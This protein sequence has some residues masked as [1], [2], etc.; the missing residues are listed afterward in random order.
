MATIDEVLQ[1]IRYLHGAELRG[2]APTPDAGT[3]HVFR[4]R[5]ERRGSGSDAS[6]PCF[7]KVARAPTVAGATHAFENE[8]AVLTALSTS[9]IP[10]PA[11]HAAGGAPLPYLLLGALPGVMVWD[12]VDPRRAAHVPAAALH[13]LAQ[14]G[15]ALARIH[16]LPLA[17]SPQRRRKIESLEGSEPVEVDGSPGILDWLRANVP[18]Q[19]STGFVHGDFNVANVLLHDG[20]VSAVLDWEYAGKGWREYELA[21]ALRAR[22]HFLDTPAEREAL[23]G[24]YADTGRYDPQSLRWCEVLNYLHFARWDRTADGAYRQFALARAHALMKASG[25]G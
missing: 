9:G 21:W 6:A 4:C 23:L 2:L 16:A 8:A 11:V 14:F 5:L 1:H 24:G 7:L 19:R 15:A 17:W 18:A 25:R 13:G 22:T 3:H 12:L 10:V 20:R